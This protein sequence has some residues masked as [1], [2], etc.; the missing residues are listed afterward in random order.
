MQFFGPLI[1]LIYVLRKGPNYNYLCIVCKET[2]HTCTAKSAN[3]C[4]FFQICLASYRLAPF[5]LWN[6]MKTNFPL[7]CLR[8]LIAVS[9]FYAT[10]LFALLVYAAISAFILFIYLFT[11]VHDTNSKIC[12]VSLVYYCNKFPQSEIPLVRVP[13]R[14]LVMNTC[15]TF[16]DIEII[17]P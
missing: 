15:V 16:S 4:S 10:T 3:K 7:W 9:A 2:E 17:L 11:N 5:N 14:I 6:V 12:P 13:P 8:W 1:G